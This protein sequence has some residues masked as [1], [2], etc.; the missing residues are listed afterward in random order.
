MAAEKTFENKVKKFLDAEGCY[1]VKYWG[2]GY[3][4]RSGVPDLL[5]CVNGHF[6][7]IELKAQTGKPSRLQLLNIE[8]I[9]KAGGRAIK[10]YPDD[11]EMFKNLIKD[12]KK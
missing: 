11:F 8:Q 7:G 5:V 3:F 12:L 2:G 9:K 4:T 1:Y 6:L 10:L